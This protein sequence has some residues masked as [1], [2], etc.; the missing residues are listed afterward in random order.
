MARIRHKKLS[1]AKQKVRESKQCLFCGQTFFRVPG[2]SNKD[3]QGQKYCPGYKCQGLAR[4]K[5]T[6]QL[7]RKGWEKWRKDLG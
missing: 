7:S 3:W 5:P 1:A 4:R 2:R 6:D